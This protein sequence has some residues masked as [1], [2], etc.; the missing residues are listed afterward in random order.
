MLNI[1]PEKN[2]SCQKIIKSKVINPNLNIQILK[3]LEANLKDLLSLFLKPSQ[4]L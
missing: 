1:K 4:G 2:F 3:N